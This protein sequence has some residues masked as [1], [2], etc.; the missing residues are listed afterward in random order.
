MNELSQHAFLDSDVDGVCDA[1]C[2]RPKDDPI[3]AADPRDVEPMRHADPA[4]HAEL[5]REGE[6]LKEPGDG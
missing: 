1:G 2:G 3:H 6:V 4:R 5:V